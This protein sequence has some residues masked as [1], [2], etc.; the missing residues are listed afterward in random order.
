LLILIPVVNRMVQQRLFKA[1][2][3]EFAVIGEPINRSSRSISTGEG[4]TLTLNHVPKLMTVRDH[5]SR[6]SLELI[7]SVRWVS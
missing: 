5:A 1:A 7:G 3:D 2:L 4:V 6:L